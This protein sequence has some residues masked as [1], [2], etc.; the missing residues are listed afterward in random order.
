MYKKLETSIVELGT[1]IQ[2]GIPT[3]F[4]FI[5]LNVND[6]NISRSVQNT[7]G[8]NVY[9]THVNIFVT[10][11]TGN[12]DYNEWYDGSACEHIIDISTTSDNYPTNQVRKFF[13]A[14]DIQE[15]WS[16]YIFEYRNSSGSISNT[17]FKPTVTQLKFDPPI[18]C[19]NNNYVRL[20]RNGDSTALTNLRICVIGFY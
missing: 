15:L 1:N 18:L 13:E 7:T 5:N 12:T 16:R 3:Y 11:Q 8:S 10:D 20:F 19:E 6:S 17:N 4:E 2:T 9:I 14:R